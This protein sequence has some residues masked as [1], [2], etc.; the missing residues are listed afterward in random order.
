LSRP[1]IEGETV[2]PRNPEP[3]ILN[4]AWKVLSEGS[5]L[6]YPTDTLYALGGLALDAAVGQAVRSAKGREESKPLPVI[7]GD[8]A[9]VRD[10]SSA[11]SETARRL[12]ESFWPGPLTLV[13]PARK[14]L[15][16]EI[17]TGT[18]AVRIP[19]HP[20]ARRLCELG[21]LISTSANRAGEAGP[22][23]CREA[24]EA[25]GAFARLALDG[26]AGSRVPSTILDLAEGVPRILRPGAVSREAIEEVLRE[27]VC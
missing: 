20:L 18:V 1:G 26:G 5:L 2:D 13:L 17:A 8:L 16:P 15:P 4:R 6:I 24:V 21:P 14:S 11:F 25:V 27:P 19:A 12:A 7:A 22:T 3:A 9:Q 23:T 10:L